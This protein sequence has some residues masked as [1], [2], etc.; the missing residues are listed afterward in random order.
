MCHEFECYDWQRIAERN[1]KKQPADALKD[2]D[3]TELVK[4]PVNPE[5]PA[6]RQPVAA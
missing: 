4:Q 2:Q 3:R 6:G 5:K 1:G